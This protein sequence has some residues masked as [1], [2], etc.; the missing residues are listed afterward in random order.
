MAVC[1][2]L[3][4]PYRLKHEIAPGAVGRMMERTMEVKFTKGPRFSTAQKPHSFY[5]LFY[6]PRNYFNINFSQAGIVSAL[7]HGHGL[8]WGRRESFRAPLG[9]KKLPAYFIHVSNEKNSEV[10]LG[11]LRITLKMFCCLP[12]NAA[13]RNMER[14]FHQTPRITLLNVIFIF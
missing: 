7:S 12:K 13:C 3:G 2:K 5:K 14:G 9:H 1:Q 11:V 10:L 6:G 8:L 4:E